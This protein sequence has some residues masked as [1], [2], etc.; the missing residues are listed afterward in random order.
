MVDVN[1]YMESTSKYLKAADLTAGT[2]FPL[3]ITGVSETEFDDNPCK[4]TLHF[5]QTEKL[6]AMPKC[7]VGTISHV[8]GNETDAWIGRNIFVYSTPVPLGDKMVNAVRVE[9]PMVEGTMNQQ[10]A[11]AQDFRQQTQQGQ[12]HMQNQ[13]PQPSNQQ[14]PQHT[15]VPPNFDFD[16]DIPF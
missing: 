14:P 9:L 1:K 7:C 6:W 3:T 11:P 10:Q 8:Y 12:Q 5:Q 4:L 16:D 15:K 13:A 2:K